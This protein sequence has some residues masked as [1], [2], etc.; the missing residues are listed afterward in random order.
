[1]ALLQGSPFPHV[2][3]KGKRGHTRPGEAGKH[4]PTRSTC[5]LLESQ[6]RDLR[7]R[8]ASGVGGGGG[9][10]DC[11][12]KYWGRGEKLRPG[13]GLGVREDACGPRILK[14]TELSE[15]LGPVR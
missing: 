6:I 14:I 3:S 4:P 8:N 11:H 2:A 7:A 12:G 1:M 15:H 9:V 13:L 10:G 5:L